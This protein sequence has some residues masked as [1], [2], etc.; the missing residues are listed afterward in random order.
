M[1]FVQRIGIMLD[2]HFIILP[3]QLLGSVSTSL[4]RDSWVC[5]LADARIELLSRGHC[6]KEK[7]N[8]LRMLLTSK[9]LSPATPKTGAFLDSIFEPKRDGSYRIVV[10]GSPANLSKHPLLL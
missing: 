1:L 2:G 3:D 4:Y 9:A 10:N 5:K 6:N 7:R 8:A